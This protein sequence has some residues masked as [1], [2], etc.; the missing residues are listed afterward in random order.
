MSIQRI[1]V[2][3]VPVDIC[4]PQELESRIMELVENPVQNRLCFFLY[5][6]F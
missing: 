6:I 3:G 5:G 4:K 1:Y 2:L